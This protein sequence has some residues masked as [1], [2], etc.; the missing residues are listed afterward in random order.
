[1]GGAKWGFTPKGLNDYR[2]RRDFIV[3]EQAP[4]NGQGSKVTTSTF[5]IGKAFDP[6][7]L[8]VLWSGDRN[9]YMTDFYMVAFNNSKFSPN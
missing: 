5:T 7:T 9:C 3:L 1:M 8:K 4:L 2:S 6:S